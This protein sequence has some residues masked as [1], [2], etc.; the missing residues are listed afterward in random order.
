ML[1][2]LYAGNYNTQDGLVNGAEGIFK[3]Y[4]ICNS[5]YDMVWIHFRDANIGRQ[6]RAKFNQQY[7]INIS[8]YWKVI[9]RITNPL[10]IPQNKSC[11]A[12]RK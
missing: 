7:D 2:E 6:K 11:I 10:A 9:F 12:F 1:V 8:Q 5:E 3:R 4:T